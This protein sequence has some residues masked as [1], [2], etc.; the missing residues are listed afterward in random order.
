MNALYL[1]QQEM[2]AIKEIDVREAER[3]VEQALDRA[4]ANIL[5]DLQ[6]LGCGQHITDQLRRYERD[7]ANYAKAKTATKRA[8]TR[9]RAWSS[10]HDVIYAIRDMQLRVEEQEKETELIRIDDIIAPPS[11]FRDRIEVRVHYQ[12]RRTVDDPWAFGTISFVHDVDMRPDYSLP[13][14]KRKLSAAK[15]E[16]KRQETLYRHWEQLR[17]LALYA[18]REFL[19]SGG[20]GIMIPETFKA[21]PA[22]ENRYLNNFSCDFGRVDES[23]AS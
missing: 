7:L 21:K 12:W 19:K 5:Y 1:S 14:P 22:R 6:L 2:R 10:G 13:Q 23:D 16:H 8:E 11:Q 3:C 20:D 17:G 9:S 15:Q 4:N 18:V